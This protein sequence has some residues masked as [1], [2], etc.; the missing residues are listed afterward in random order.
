[1]PP[2]SIHLLE[3]EDDGAELSE[4]NSHMSYATDAWPASYHCNETKWCRSVADPAE[5]VSMFLETELSLGQLD[6]MQK[7]LWFAG[8]RRP[9]M[10]LHF[11]LAMGRQIVVADRMDLHLLWG[12]EGRIFLKPIPRFFLDPDFWRSKLQCDRDCPCEGHKTLLSNDGARSHQPSNHEQT[13]RLSC[14]GKLREVALGFLYTYACLIS[15]EADFLVANDKRLLPRNAKDSTIKWQDWKQLARELLKN[16]DPDKVHPRFLR[17]ELRLSRINTIH[18]VAH[19]SPLDPYLRRWYNYGGL[20]R[21][22]LSCIAAATVFVALV[23]TAMQVGLAT[24]RLGKDH[25]FQQASYGFTVFA[26]LGPMVMFGLVVL[27]ALANLVKDMRGFLETER[28]IR[29]GS[30]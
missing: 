28:Q 19:I 10:Q 11:Q 23:L 15:S 26:I 20:F 6:S 27:G 7:Y 13:S 18:R 30:V 16:H 1:M 14:K 21:D 9:A 5:D 3:T 24:D 4:T 12:N 17:A 2:F 22:N 25:G 29:T 8:S